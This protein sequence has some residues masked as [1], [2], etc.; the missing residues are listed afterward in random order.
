M[1]G[2]LARYYILK[3]SKVITQILEWRVDALWRDDENV[4]IIDGVQ[5]VFGH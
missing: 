2:R 3:F 1:V 4:V 5:M